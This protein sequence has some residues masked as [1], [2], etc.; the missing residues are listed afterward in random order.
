MQIPGA[1][2][3][4]PTLRWSRWAGESRCAGP[5]GAPTGPGDPRLLDPAATAALVDFFARTD[6]ITTAIANEHQIRVQDS[7]QQAAELDSL[8]DRAA[9]QAAIDR[10]LTAFENGTL[11]ETTCGRRITDL[12]TQLDQLNQRRAEP[13]RLRRPAC[14]RLP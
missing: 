13:L 6:L 4:D 12:N 10:Y 1:T 7:A 3:G 14:R 11:D 8:T 2:P 9:T 5:C